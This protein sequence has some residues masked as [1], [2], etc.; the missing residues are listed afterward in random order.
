MLSKKPSNSKKETA[1]REH[2]LTWAAGIVYAIG[3]ANFIFDKSQKIHMTASELAEPFG[4]SKTTAAQKASEIINLVAF[5]FYGID[6]HR[7]VK[8]Q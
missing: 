2:K 6:K 8:H 4:I 5:L 3:S 7:A 1:K